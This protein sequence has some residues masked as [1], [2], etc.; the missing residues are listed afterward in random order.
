[1]Q[2]DRHL[3][4]DAMRDALESD[5][6]AGLTASPKTLPPKWF[7]DARGSVLFDEI[8]RLPEYYPTRCEREILQQHAGAIAVLSGADTLIELG[9]GTSEKT[10]LLL[11]ALTA[12]GTLRRFVPFD[13][14]E[15]VLTMAGKQIGDEY[16]DVE[17]H[18][19]V[20]DFEHHLP[21]LPTGGRRLVAFLGGTIG[22]L[23]PDQRAEFLATLAATLAPGDTLL[24][25]TD[26]VKDAARLV[27]AYDDAQ[28]VTAEFN[29]NVLRVIARE[30]DADLDV[31]AFRHLSVWDAEQE[32]VEMRLESLTDQTVQLR[33]L[34]LTVEL[35]AGEQIRT[36]ISA[37]FR[38]PRVRAE[39]AAAGLQLQRWWTDDAGDFGVSLAVKP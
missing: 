38:E 10:R 6:R 26:I 27:A 1:M 2:L 12:A 13:V 22:N 15:S 8:T 17:I 25:G 3:A 20:G 24:L 31:S 21:L 29:K 16:P 32:W 33:A 19:V 4:P 30:L 23:L 11:D 14:D 7:Y 18:A 9:S 28:G 35:A 5:V 39:L 36:E 34:D 37:K